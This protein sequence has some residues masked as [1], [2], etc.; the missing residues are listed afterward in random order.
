MAEE[1]SYK[2]EVLEMGKVWDVGGWISSYRKM[3]R[4]F[5]EA[6]KMRGFEIKS[7]KIPCQGGPF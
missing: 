4:S 1:K 2:V 7:A 6:L 5:R 3:V